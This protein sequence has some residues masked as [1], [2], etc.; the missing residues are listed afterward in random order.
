MSDINTITV[1]GRL[2]QDPEL[3]FTQSG[4]AFLNLSIAT[5]S[6]Y[7]NKDGE[8][9]DDTQ[10]HRATLWGKRAEALA[11]HLTKGAIVGITGA[12]QYRKYTANDG[13]ERTSAD[14]R[15]FDVAL[16]GGSRRDNGAAPAPAD[17]G[18]GEVDYSDD[19]PF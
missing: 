3:K 19:I 14:I 9:V 4:Q 7:K 18:A 6:K 12:M 8:L 5:S 1:V 16:Y 2:G 13:A 15:V 10:W 11:N 17:N